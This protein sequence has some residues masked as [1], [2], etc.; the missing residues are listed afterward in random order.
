MNTPSLRAAGTVLRLL[1]PG[2]LTLAL[3]GLGG[4]RAEAQPNL[5]LNKP[6]TGSLPCNVNEGPARDEPA[7]GGRVGSGVGRRARS[8]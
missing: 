4:G 6:V 8:L 3:L 5:A 1:S 7:S 2:L